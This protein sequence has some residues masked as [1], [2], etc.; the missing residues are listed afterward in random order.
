[1]D[2]QY[3]V[4]QKILYNLENIPDVLA[5]I[6]L[7]NV[8]IG[9]TDDLL[10][11]LDP[12]YPIILLAFQSFNPDSQSTGVYSRGCLIHQDINYLVKRDNEV[13]LVGSLQEMMNLYAPIESEN[14]ALSYALAVTGY[15]AIYDLENHPDYKVISSPLEESYVKRTDDGFIVHLFD[16]FMCG[17]GPHITPAVDVLVRTDGTI[18]EVGRYDAFRDPELDQVCFD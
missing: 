17:C 9:R 2:Y 1:V 12:K 16:T 6:D 3:F 15:G 8:F 10:G 4:D 13:Q 7:A 18:A 5:G 14:E 11:G